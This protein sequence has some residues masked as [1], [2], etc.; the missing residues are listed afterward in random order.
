MP[1]M[2]TDDELDLLGRLE[3][4]EADELFVELMTAHHIGGIEMA[5]FAATNGEND[6]VVKMASGMAS[7]QAGEIGEMERLLE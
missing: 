3:G 2:A 4:R 1:G 7:A 5:Q 6:E